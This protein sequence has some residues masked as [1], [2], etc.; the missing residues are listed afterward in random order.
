[1]TSATATLSGATNDAS[2]S[3][4]FYLYDGSSCS[5]NQ[6]WVSQQDVNAG[7]SYESAENEFDQSGSF[8]WN[9]VYSG[10]Q[11]NS[12]ATSNC[13]TIEVSSLP[14]PEISITVNQTIVDEPQSLLI[15]NITAGNAGNQNYTFAGDLQLRTESGKLYETFPS[16]V[17][18][19]IS[20]PASGRP[21]AFPAGVIP[22]GGKIAGEVAF[23]VPSNETAFALVYQDPYS[24]VNA[25]A[26]IP[27]VSS[28]VSEVQGTGTVTITPSDLAC[29][30]G[31]ELGACFTGQYV[32]LNDSILGSAD[33]YTGQ[34]VGVQVTIFLG[35]GQGTLLGFTAISG[36]SA[37]Q[38]V[39]WTQFDCTGG[40]PTCS[41]WTFD[42][43]LTTTPGSSYSGG[44]DIVVSLQQ[45]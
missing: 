11:Y 22:A 2:G 5:G 20:W 31:G 3:I 27:P 4:V 10:D 7:G 23:S 19:A 36:V 12:G 39:N 32:L 30:F 42:I 38:V 16:S 6:E 45:G 1:L 35:A 29:G 28:W 15:L 21:H 18:Y 9:A 26:S 33:F 37:F 8:S 17:T 41:Q 24:G 44:P 40:D 34:V 13:A 14:A 25:T 43:Y